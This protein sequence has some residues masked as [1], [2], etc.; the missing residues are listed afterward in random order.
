DLMFAQVGKTFEQ[1]YQNELRGDL[2]FISNSIVNRSGSRPN[3]DGGPTSEGYDGSGNNHDSNVNMQYIDIDGDPSTFSSS[4]AT[5]QFD[6]SIASTCYAPVYAGLYWSGMKGSAST[7]QGGISDNANVDEIR[8]RIPG[9][10]GYIDITADDSF[11][12]T[13]AFNSERPYYCYADISAHINTLTDLSGEYTVA[14]IRT[15]TGVHSDGGGAGGWIIVLV[16]ENPTLSAKYISS[17]D[18]F[19]FVTG[20]SNSGNTTTDFSYSGFQ[21]TPVG[22]VDAS[23]GVGAIEGDR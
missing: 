23:I 2:T 8:L 6:G 7:S 22:D 15:L 14:N 11:I 10:A 12:S 17:F 21:T 16:Y 1:R 3:D 5:L 4:S 19:A 18:G 13:S 9:G 20:P